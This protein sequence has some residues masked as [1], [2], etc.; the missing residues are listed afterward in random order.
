MGGVNNFFFKREKL[1]ISFYYVASYFLSIYCFYHFIVPIYGYTGFKWQPVN[2]KI[3]EGLVIL[4]LVS[5]ILPC[6]FKKPSDFFLHFQFMF[7]IVPMLI[8]YGV[9]DYS[10]LFLYFTITLFISIVLISSMGGVKIIRMT[11]LSIVFFMRFLLILSWAGILAI[12]LLGGL[13]YLNFDMSKVYD[14]RDAASNNLPGVFGYISPLISK[15]LL[16]FSFLLAFVQRDKISAMLSFFGSVIMFGLTA[17]KGPLFYPFVVLGV[18]YVSG[19]NNFIE[20]LLFVYLFIVVLALIDFI[21]FGGNVVGSL[22]FRRSYLVPAF[23]NYTYYDFFSTNPFYYWSQ[24]KVSLGLSEMTYS[25]SPANL[26]GLEYFGSEE[27]GAN[28]GWIG[29]GY[30]NAGLLG[31]ALYSVIIGYLMRI[32]NTYS[33]NIDKRVLI[34]IL[35]APML[36]LIASSDLPSAFLNHGLLLSLVLFSMFSIPSSQKIQ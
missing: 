27:T 17:H 10:R 28:T 16:P 33:K 14:F 30:M 34:S 24:S 6:R 26:I 25:L 2:F 18:Y 4:F 36:T 5:L 15:V 31:M 11:R 8:L 21:L 35:T 12:I 32:L 3:I 29:S 9:S 19:K 13:K 22:A 23:L 7:P 1:A 20:K